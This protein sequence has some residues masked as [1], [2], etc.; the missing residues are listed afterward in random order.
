MTIRF[1]QVCY[2]YPNSK[3][4]VSDLSLSIERG[5]LLALIGASGSGKT[6]LLKLLAGFLTPDRGCIYIDGNDVTRLPPRQRELGLVFQTYALFGHMS[7]WRNVAYPLKVRGIPR[8]TA[9]SRKPAATYQ[10]PPHCRLS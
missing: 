3:A 10:R 5:E 1:E 2:T 7:A 4:G 8:C 9:R 6:T